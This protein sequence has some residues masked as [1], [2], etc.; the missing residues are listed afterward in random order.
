MTGRRLFAPCDA[1]AVTEVAPFVAGGG[2]LQRCRP[3]DDWGSF[4]PS[5]AS[6][7]GS[8]SRDRSRL[9]QF[10][11]E[12]EHVH[13]NGAALPSGGDPS[14]LDPPTDSPLADPEQPPRLS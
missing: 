4:S 3:A 8:S 1:G 12:A 5:S 10:A 9:L 13:N 14:P 6:W 7:R 2:P 11:V